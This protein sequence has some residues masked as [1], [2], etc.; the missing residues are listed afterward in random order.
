MESENFY[1]ISMKYDC[2]AYTLKDLFDMVEKGI[3]N[4]YEFFQIT[5]YSYKGIKQTKGW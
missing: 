2:G 4:E 1:L 5:R 3:I